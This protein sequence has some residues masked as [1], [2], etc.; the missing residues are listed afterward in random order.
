[1]GAHTACVVVCSKAKH[2]FLFL[3]N[4]LP[5]ES[6]AALGF[7]AMRNLLVTDNCMIISDITESEFSDI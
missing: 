6:L 4:L 2:L 7:C 1:M 5:E 3:I